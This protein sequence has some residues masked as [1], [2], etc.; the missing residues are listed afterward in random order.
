MLT[1][2]I[3][4]PFEFEDKQKPQIKTLCDDKKIPKCTTD[5]VIPEVDFALTG[6]YTCHYEGTIQSPGVNSD[7]IYIYV[8]G[9]SDTHFIL[10]L[11]KLYDFWQIRTN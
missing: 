3:P 1:T 4:S 10:I 5:V 9:K 6:Y 7:S 8:N 11:N 2:V